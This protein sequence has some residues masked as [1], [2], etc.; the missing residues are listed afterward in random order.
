[1]NL[2]HKKSSVIIRILLG[3]FICIGFLYS[4]TLLQI[5]QCSEISENVR[6]FGFLSPLIYALI[7]ILATIF[8]IPGTVLTLIAGLVF[9][10]TQGTIIVIFAA[11]IGASLAFLMSRYLVRN[12][13]ESRIKR[14][15]WFQKLEQ[16]LLDNGL[17]F[18][19][20]VRIVPLFPFNGLNY[21]CGILPIRFKDFFIGSLLGMLPG[22]FAY[23]YL[24]ETGCKVIDSVLQ[25]K[26]SFSDFPDDVKYSFITAVSF[27]AILS[28]LPIIIKKFFRNFF[29]Q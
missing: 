3:T 13:I 16:S 11:T 22:T 21:A 6:G 29:R 20:F 25:K 10:T 28:I 9:G 14:Q 1:M 17:S 7:Y 18:M 4:S 8:F 23:V 27:L 19:L 5:P 2:T 24:G 26:L 12:M 15:G